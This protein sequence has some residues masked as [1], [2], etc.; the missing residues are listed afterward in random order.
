MNN[1]KLRNDTN[2][3]CFNNYLFCFFLLKYYKK[4][5]SNILYLSFRYISII[6]INKD[7]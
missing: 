4:V 7:N 5:F 3:F 1:N 6:I 2:N